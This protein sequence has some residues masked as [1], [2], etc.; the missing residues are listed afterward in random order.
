VI[1]VDELRFYELYLYWYW[2][3]CRK[4]KCW[5]LR[6]MKS[7]VG[8]R[9]DVTSS[10]IWHFLCLRHISTVEYTYS[11]IEDCRRRHFDVM[12]TISADVPPN[13]ELQPTQNKRTT[14]TPLPLPSAIGHN[15]F[16]FDGIDIDLRPPPA[17]AAAALHR[18]STM[19]CPFRMH[20]S[21]PHA[22]LHH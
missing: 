4:R 22:H 10:S 13:L 12:M 14:K 9:S 20:S 11:Y 6:A 1:D 19:T 7:E 8:S 21:R 17:A 5:I 15:I 18:L 2:Y 3:R 16:C